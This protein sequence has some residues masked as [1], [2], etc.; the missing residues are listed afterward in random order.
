MAD[1]D[2]TRHG[3]EG[4]LVEH[5]TDQTEVLEDQN[6][7]PVGYRD[8]GRLLATVLKGVEAVVGEF[9]DFLTGSPDAEYAAFFPRW[10]FHLAGHDMGC[11][12]TGFRLAWP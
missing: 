5:L 6:L 9:G 4:L 1:G 8:T 7:R 2:V 11:S 12:L 3:P 10:V